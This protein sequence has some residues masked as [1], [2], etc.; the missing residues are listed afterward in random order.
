MAEVIERIW[1]VEDAARRNRSVSVACFGNHP[2]AIERQAA[3]TH[4]GPISGA[5]WFRRLSQSLAVAGADVENLR[6]AGLSRAKGAYIQGLARK[7]LEG[8][9][10]SLEQ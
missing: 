9:V 8:I 3:S 2:P 5:F 7:T 4:T 1:T 10:P 6:S